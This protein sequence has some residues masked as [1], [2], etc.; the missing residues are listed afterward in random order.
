MEMPLGSVEIFLHH[1]QTAPD[2]EF[3]A[4]FGS[5]RTE[6]WLIGVGVRRCDRVGVSPVG[7][8]KMLAHFARNSALTLSG[9]CVFFDLHDLQHYDCS[10]TVSA[11]RPGHSGHPPGRR[12]L[13]RAGRPTIQ[14]TRKPSR[15]SHGVHGHHPGPATRLGRFTATSACLCSYWAQFSRTAGP[16]WRKTMRRRRGR[17]EKHRNRT[18]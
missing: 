3:V 10:G 13:R 4:Y 17:S 6:P 5:C 8:L 1:F 16:K 7:I 18:T 11:T 9:S 14:Q 2:G 15:T 12:D